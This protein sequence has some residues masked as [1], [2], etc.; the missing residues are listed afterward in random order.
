MDVLLPVRSAAV[1]QHKLHLVGQHR[2]KVE[3]KV[4]ESVIA[5]IITLLLDK[6]RLYRLY[7]CLLLIIVKFGIPAVTKC[8]ETLIS[9]LGNLNNSL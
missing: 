3:I 5:L 1:H 2:Y 4:K 9:P 6:I 7:M 8:W